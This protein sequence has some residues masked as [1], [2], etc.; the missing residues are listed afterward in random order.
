[1]AQ[2]DHI[3]SSTLPPKQS[4]TKQLP[5]ENSLLDC[6]VIELVKHYST[7]TARTVSQIFS[8]LTFLTDFLKGPR[9]S[10]PQS[11]FFLHRTSDKPNSDVCKAIPP[12]LLSDGCLPQAP[13][14]STMHLVYVPYAAVVTVCPPSGFTSF[15]RWSRTFLAKRHLTFLLKVNTRNIDL[16]RIE[17]LST[18]YHSTRLLLTFHSNYVPGMLFSS[19]NLLRR[20]PSPLLQE[21]HHCQAYFDE[22][23]PAISFYWRLSLAQEDK[24]VSYSQIYSPS[25]GFLAACLYFTDP[26]IS[27]KW[28]STPCP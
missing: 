23:F 6:D 11:P 28:R 9:P 4:C 8:Q 3:L 12:C 19:V 10:F 25:L 13:P 18:S 24:L 26:S 14:K 7:L 22:S 27:N 21:Y 17:T 16:S 15:P 5:S 1:M 20:Y 2:K